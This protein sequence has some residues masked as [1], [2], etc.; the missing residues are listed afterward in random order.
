MRITMGRPFK[1]RDDA[2]R[3]RRNVVIDDNGCWIW[4]LKVHKTG[5]GH[6]TVPRNAVRM[7]YLVHRFAY[8]ALVGEIPEGL[9]LD[10]LCRVRACCNPEHLEPVTSREN[11]ARSPLNFVGINLAKTRCAQDHPFNDE[12]TRRTP[13]GAREC[14]ICRR[15]IGQRYRI[16]QALRAAGIEVA[17]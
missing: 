3:V 8:E 7:T 15:E 5:Y 10:H 12:N 13:S 4:Q 6:V 17:A 1:Y 14:R 9:Q 2:E 11:S 16:R